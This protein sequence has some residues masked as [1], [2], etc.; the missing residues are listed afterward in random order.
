MVMSY[1]YSGKLSRRAKKTIV[2]KKISK[3][4]LRKKKSEMKNAYRKHGF[5]L[6]L[7]PSMFCPFCGC[8][9]TRHVNHHVG[10]PELWIEDFCL[11]CGGLFGFADNS[12]YR[13]TL[14][15]ELE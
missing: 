3:T 6:D 11:R 5:D 15:E 7:L 8:S 13:L 1:E 2:G 14:L 12:E 10:Y 9:A 4:A